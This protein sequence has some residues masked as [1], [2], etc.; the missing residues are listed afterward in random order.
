MVIKDTIA[1]ERTSTN[2]MAIRQDI[3]TLSIHDKSSS[4]AG[5]RSVGIKRAGLTEMDRDRTLH[6][7]FNCR[8][9]LERGFSSRGSGW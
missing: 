8:L 2:H 5:H 6:D 3:A 7:L 4:L 9:P 1:P